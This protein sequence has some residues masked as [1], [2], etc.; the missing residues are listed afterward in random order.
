MCSSLADAQARVNHKIKQI[1]HQ[2][3][4]HKNQG[5]QAQVGG[6]H[7]DVG[8]R[9][10]LD[11]QQ[12]HTWPLKNRLGDDGKGNQ[13]PQLQP[14]DGD[15]RYQRIFQC[16]AKVNGPVAQTPGTGKADVVGTQDLQHF[17]AHQTQDECELKNRQRDGGQQHM[18]P[19]VNG[20]QAAA[21]GAKLHDFAAPETGEPTQP[22]G[23]N[24]N[25]QNANQESGQRYAQQRHQ[26][27]HLTQKTATFE[28]TVNPQGQPDEQGQQGRHQRELQRR[29]EALDDQ[30]RYLGTLAQTQT[31]FT[32]HGIQAEVPELYK[33]RLIQAQVDAQQLDLLGP[34]IL[35]QQK[36]DRVTPVSY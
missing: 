17:S 1:H 3:D 15:H 33:K 22:H 31:K 10:C 19:A 32:L 11:E 34:G 7:R 13:L 23:K 30:A 14:G 27:K 16:V 18:A 36:H 2:V 9:D 5:N 25:Q 26:H 20:K 29:R 21:P 35:P 6:H 4:Q 28:R 8:K 24:Q 12:A